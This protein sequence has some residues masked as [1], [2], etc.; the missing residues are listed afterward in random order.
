MNRTTKLIAYTLFA[1]LFPFWIFLGRITEKSSGSTSISV[2]PA[3]IR[4]LD[5]LLQNNKPQP[6][7]TEALNRVLL[8]MALSDSLTK[9]NLEILTTKL[10][11][12]FPA[13]YVPGKI[14]V[15]FTP[16]VITV[17]LPDNKGAIPP[18]SSNL[19][20]SDSVK[21]EYDALEARF[22]QL[23]NN[24]KDTVIVDIFTV[25]ASARSFLFSVRD[26]FMCCDQLDSALSRLLFRLDTAHILPGKANN[27][28]PT[29]LDARKI[30]LT[31]QIAAYKS[32]IRSKN[33]CSKKLFVGIKNTSGSMLTISGPDSLKNARFA[34]K[35]RIFANKEDLT[36]RRNEV[37]YFELTPFCTG[38]KNWDYSYISFTGRVVKHRLAPPSE[39]VLFVNIQRQ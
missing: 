12:A 15:T 8:N 24:D 11:G 13:K 34:G 25:N 19:V 14:D 29:Q 22:V 1:L 18:P 7:N 20:N 26:S 31:K 38:S 36:I 27:P 10:N 2:D 17:T 16:P 21:R 39:G 37:A 4:Q 6:V 30:N 32:E 33:G 5:T 9:R 28:E 23:K 35:N 3:T